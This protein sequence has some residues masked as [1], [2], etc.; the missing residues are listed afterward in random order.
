LFTP[1]V[2]PCLFA[3]YIV[4]NHYVCNT[5]TLRPTVKNS[6]SEIFLMFCF[7][8]LQWLSTSR[9]TS[10]LKDSNVFFRLS[11]NYQPFLINFILNIIYSQVDQCLGSILTMMTTKYIIKKMIIIYRIKT[12]NYH[13]D[14]YSG[15][16]RS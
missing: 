4:I 16:I 8:A 12:D 5:L 10:V 2:S 9:N 7:Q 6:I 15:P 14:C 13:K 1:R 3:V 11:L